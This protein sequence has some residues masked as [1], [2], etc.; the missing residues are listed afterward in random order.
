M[1]LEGEVSGSPADWLRY[2]VSDLEI[3]RTTNKPRE[4]PLRT[5]LKSHLGK[6]FAL[7]PS[8]FFKTRFLP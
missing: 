4:K 7:K 2:A 1:R 3:A 5:C 8:F 6:L